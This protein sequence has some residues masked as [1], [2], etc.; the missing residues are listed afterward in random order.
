METCSWALQC[1]IQSLEYQ[2]CL[3][4]PSELTKTPPLPVQRRRLPAA[5]RPKNLRFPGLE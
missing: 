1:H 5:G 4:W 3:A 2:C